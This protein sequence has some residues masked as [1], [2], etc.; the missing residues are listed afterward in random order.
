[1]GNRISLIIPVYNVEKYLSQCMDSVLKQTVAF[2]EIIL[3]DDGSNDN[4]G[5]MCD[6]YSKR[7]SAVQVIHKKNGGLSEAR[8]VG[9]KASGSD[10]ILLLDSDDSIDL[11]TCERFKNMCSTN[12]D[13]IVGNLRIVTP[14]KT[15]SRPHTLSD[16]SNIINGVDYLK[17]EYRS[18]TMHM[19]S[20][21]CL[22]N[23]R[24]LIDNQI[25]FTKGLLHEDELFTPIVFE[26]AK[27][28][29]PTSIEFYNHMLRDGSITM[30]KDKTENAKSI[31][32]I[33]YLLED[34]FHKTQDVVL[35][36]CVLEHCVDLY[37]KVFVDAELLKHK[38][39]RISRRYLA[40]HSKSLKNRFRTLEYML[41]PSLL[42]YSERRRRRII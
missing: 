41:S 19:A 35:T 36:E 32:K 23:R 9:I 16:S 13:L 26:K 38:D 17:R 4:S 30:R 18:G 7:F 1:M 34:Y 40:A 28:V 39:I 2:D 29:I 8:N 6:E 10:Y 20:V 22:Y 42:Y 5:N 21:Q 24:F 3:V 25:D 14:Q 15:R 37:Y 12:P 33:C 31:I 11:D 27:S